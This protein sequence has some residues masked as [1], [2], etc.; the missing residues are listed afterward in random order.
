MLSRRR[1]LSSAVAAPAVRTRASRRNIV[2]ILCDD[3]RYDFA[4]ALS[5]PWLEGHTPALDRMV[6][7][8]A[9]FRN[10]FVTT[11]QRKVEMSPSP[12]SRNVPLGPG[13]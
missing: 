12:Q 6:R 2:F 13:L 5:H 1:L 3:H 8:G 10:A 7:G 11:C 4:G 9:H